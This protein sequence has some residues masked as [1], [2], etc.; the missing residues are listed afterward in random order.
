VSSPDGT[1]EVTDVYVRVFW[2]AALGPRAIADL[3]R[4]AAAAKRGETIPEP[5]HLPNLIRARLVFCKGSD[6]LVVD[7]VPVLPPHQVQRLPLPLR[8]R[9]PTALKQAR[10]RN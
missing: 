7:R 2:V 3:L 1:L 5:Q 6:L 4:L 8:R 9:H 10:L